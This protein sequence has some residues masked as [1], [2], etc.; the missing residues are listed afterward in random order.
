MDSRGDRGGAGAASRGA[1]LV[2]QP[3]FQ[4]AS[5]GRG[6]AHLASNSLHDRAA[7]ERRSAAATGSRPDADPMNAVIVIDLDP[8]LIQIGGPL[9]TWHGVFSVLG[10]LA[11]WRLGQWLA[12]RHDRIEPAKISD[13]AVWMVIVGLIGARLLFIW[14][15]YKQF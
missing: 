12:W 4:A 7:A 5:G 3:A 14:E 9:I 11:A 2:S 10:I 15:N 1:R 13:A 6:G 8:N